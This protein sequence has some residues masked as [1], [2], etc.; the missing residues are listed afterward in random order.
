MPPGLQSFLE[1][2]R[3]LRHT[4]TVFGRKGYSLRSWE[5]LPS[6]FLGQV[7]QPVRFFHSFHLAEIFHSAKQRFFPKALRKLLFTDGKLQGQV[8]RLL[9]EFIDLLKEQAFTA[10]QVPA[11][12]QSA[13]PLQPR[14]QRE[15]AKKPCTVSVQHAALHP[16]E[17]MF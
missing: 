12:L 15:Q 10:V 14:N 2:C 7:S 11:D 8:A 13:E 1:V 9:P 3:I 6:V 16:A 17:Q 5:P 4:S